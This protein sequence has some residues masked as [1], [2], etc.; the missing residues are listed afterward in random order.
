MI[1][2]QLF[3]LATASGLLLAASFTMIALST[4]CTYAGQLLG[5]HFITGTDQYRA[6]EEQFLDEM[7]RLGDD[8]DR[9]A[10]A[11]MLQR[12]KQPS[13]SPEERYWASRAI[14]KDWVSDPGADSVVL[15]RDAADAGYIPAVCDF[16]MLK[17]IG[18]FGVVKDP[19][20]I[21]MVRRAAKSGNGR[22]LYDLGVIHAD[23][24]N[25]TK[26]DIVAAHAS[27][28]QSF[29]H[30]YWPACAALAQIIWV[31]GDQ[32]TAERYFEQA[33]HLGDISAMEFLVD[34][35]HGTTVS[36]DNGKTR[37]Y[38]WRGTMWGDARLARVLA[39][40]ILLGNLG[41]VQDEA[42]AVNLLRQAA[43]SEDGV[44][45]TL[46]ARA[47][48]EGLW[49]VQ[50]QPN[51]GKRELEWLAG[52]AD[53]SGRAAYVLGMALIE[54]SGLRVDLSRGYVLIHQAANAGFVPAKEWL[55]SHPSRD[56]GAGSSP[57]DFSSSIHSASSVAAGDI[58]TL[59]KN[60]ATDVT[61]GAV[62]YNGTKMSPVDQDIEDNDAFLDW[63]YH[64]YPISQHAA[65]REL[66][67]AT[68]PNPSAR[69]LAWAA[70]GV[71]YGET[72]VSEHYPI[73]KWLREA[74][75]ADDPVAMCAYGEM[76]MMGDTIPKDQASGLKLLECA[77]VRGDLRASVYSGSAY[78][79]GGSNFNKDIDKGLS[80]LE[81]ASRQDVP[82]GMWKL[83]E[84]YGDTGDW[85]HMKPILQHAAYETNEPASALLGWILTGQVP[86]PNSASPNES[87]VTWGKLI[88]RGS[89]CQNP[90][91]QV[92]L[93]IKLN[94]FDHKDPNLS[95][96][97]L[98]R[99][100][101]RGSI[102]ARAILDGAHITGDFGIIPDVERGTRDL[103]YL[104]S[105]KP[106]VLNGAAVSDEEIGRAEA[107][108]QLGRLLYDGKYMPLDKNRGEELIQQAADGHNPEAINWL[109]ELK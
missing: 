28:E 12:A 109:R 101:E 44:A 9:D 80:L 77:H 20:G 104:V 70:L 35:C 14:M 68:Q 75:N 30:G 56:T 83:A 67:R 107:Q 76:L 8:P 13:A 66:A 106:T 25:N 16:G 42:L 24:L 33:A 37:D 15:L 84:Y 81:E 87:Y 103:N 96:M 18:A 99:A 78:L 48:L 31:Q 29:A 17:I 5:E 105:A 65:A 58:E 79:T 32:T 21:E 1:R 51:R 108:W 45:I 64:G 41:L 40:N 7:Y 95:R 74:S 4:T 71:K 2:L 102:Q 36:R 43:V 94:S 47:R 34:P 53:P 93:A 62:Q 98:R 10:A 89:L 38:L 69:S 63:W 11:R 19:N 88:L 26:I 27:F 3:V 61:G 59:L 52:G 91:L 49:G 97:L 23:G 60:A 50:R 22:A 72:S 73:T 100:A 39:A 92:Q 57:M 90:F 82:Q 54:G 46:L 85:A 55:A 86:I 6:D